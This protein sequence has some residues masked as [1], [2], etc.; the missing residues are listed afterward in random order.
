MRIEL[1]SWTSFDKD[2]AEDMTGWFPESTIS[3]GEAAAEFG[4]RGCHE[5]WHRPN[6]KTATNKD[7]LANIL[8]T[9][10]H[11]VLEHATFGLR[12]EGVSR[13]LT[14]ELVRHRH[15]SYS[16][17]SQRFVEPSPDTE[18]VRPPVLNDDEWRSL[19]SAA[20]EVIL[21]VYRE[22]VENLDKWGIK[23]K[24]AQEAARC[25]LSNMMPTS[26]LVTGNA[27]AWRSFLD[28][29]GSMGADAEMRYFAVR[30]FRV[31]S[32]HSPNLFQDYA[33]E[34]EFLSKVD[35]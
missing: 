12:I 34:G 23:S 28:A 20:S 2:V 29:R 16:Q 14:H 21:R 27:R 11:S 18:F 22:T 32:G 17:L 9:G 30:V 7:Y 8:C 24:K 26:L 31:L 6:P 13:S 15:F 33:D 19:N 1:V 5:S 35:L 10:H 3:G 25:V 4:G